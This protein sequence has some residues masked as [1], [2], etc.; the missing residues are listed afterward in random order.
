MPIALIPISEKVPPGVLCLH[1]RSFIMQTS[2]SIKL[3][4]IETKAHNQPPFL[5]FFGRYKIAVQ[6]K[7]FRSEK[8]VC[9]GVSFFVCTSP[10]WVS[11]FIDFNEEDVILTFL[12]NLFV[13]IS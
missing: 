4:T 1:S 5:K 2:V 11:I 8:Y 9:H 12:T 10:P 6:T 7:P 13:N 3:R